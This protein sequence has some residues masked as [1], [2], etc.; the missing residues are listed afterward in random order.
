MKKILFFVCTIL[1]GGYI[2]G[3]V[4]LQSIDDAHV[5]NVISLDADAT[6][7]LLISGGVDNRAH[8][9]N[10]NV[11]QKIKSFSDVEG[12]PAVIFSNNSKRFITSSYSGKIIVWDAETK[13]P[14][15]LL[16]GNV[17]DILS[18]AYNPINNNIAG[19]G[20]DGKII[21]WDQEGKM[22]MNFIGHN[23]E[24]NTVSFNAKGTKLITASN[25][26]VKIWDGN[27]FNPLKTI[28]PDSKVIKAIK[29]SYNLDEIAIVTS[30]RIIE[31]WNT[32]NYIKEYELPKA[33]H[34]IKSVEF[35]PDDKYVAIGGE[36]GSLCIIN[37]TTKEITNE[38]LNAHEASLA[39]LKFTIDG[40]KLITGGYDGKIRIWNLS[41]LN[42]QASLA[43]QKS[44]TLY[45]QS[46]ESSQPQN[47]GDK[48][49]RGDV[50][51]G[52]G[53]AYSANDLQFG[54]YY[55]LIIGIDN[56]K[57]QWS[58]LKNAVSDAKAIYQILQNKYK[59]DY[60]KEL[61]NEQATR[62]NIIKEL[63]WLVQNV[64]PSDNLLIY[65]SGHGEFN[66]TLNKGYWVPVDAT[67]ASTSYY[68]SNSDIQTFLGG[69]KSKH[70]LLISDACFSG[71]I[72]RGNTLSIPF[73]ESDKY[74]AKV[75]STS[76]RKAITS[77]GIE[78]VL[79]G[80][81]EGHSVFAY[82]LL[83]SLNGNEKK[84]YDAS[85]L[86]DNIK[87]P[88]LN[89]SDQSPQFNAIKNA[90]DEGGQFIFLKK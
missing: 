70:T 77:G 86:F 56:Y 23:S 60:L 78:P 36:D 84:Y 28:N 4:L 54:N 21:I 51:K 5:G 11:G 59:F 53:V 14:V 30:N 13:K 47:Q 12:Y 65:Y 33:N 39:E 50:L 73:E 24:I 52:L 41:G 55:A 67:A 43:Y 46:Q 90:G 15:L 48:Q 49:Y 63:E 87:I 81:K 6:G 22:L 61:I 75:N 57:G 40:L 88:V 31:V 72:F 89:N 10:A 9:W 85:Q 64:K 8:M 42:I 37:L 35:S 18:L 1:S 29:V 17:T 16:K 66:Q 3:Q 62:I 79:D 44:Q 32:E 38:I 26:E 69:I 80:G 76:S 83:K 2:S 71:D 68:I 19:G 20:K 27:N 45:A 34:D 58:P 74:Y 82:Y 25:T 7:S